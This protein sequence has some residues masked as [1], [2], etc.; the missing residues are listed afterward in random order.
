M[1][2]CQTVLFDMDGTL[3]PV[4]KAITDE[5]IHALKD[6]TD[7]RNVSVAIVTGSGIDY[8]TKQCSFLW[9]S[10]IIHSLDD[11]VL[12][13]CNGTQIYKWCDDERD[14]IEVQTASMIQK[15]GKKKY[16]L[17]IRQLLY[18]QLALLA[19]HDVPLTGEFISYR[20][21]LLNW[22]PIGRNSGDKE[23][24]IFLDL[25]KSANIRDQF[26]ELVREFCE[27]EKIDVTCALGGQ[28]S[29][30]IYP[31]GWDK[32]YAL[33][34]FEGKKCWFVGDKCTGS[35]NDK[36]IYDALK[37]FDRAY[38]TSCPEATIDIIHHEIIPKIKRDIC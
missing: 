6:L 16:R 4:R 20:K 38:Q 25:D 21:S 15:V 33:K 36:K 17:L 32:T 23:R 29:I 30:D 3:T 34:Y 12:M 1:K 35:G 22:C 5:M 9:Q 37:K 18:L 2:S 8:V 13:P 7:L 10:G 26:I 27:K 19:K 31:S 24:S 11:I 28:T 14:F